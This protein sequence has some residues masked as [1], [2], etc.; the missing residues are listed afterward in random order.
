LD[1]GWIS[2][3][4]PV[5][6]LFLV[7]V[8]KEVIFSL[9]MGT[10]VGALVFSRGD[11]FLGLKTIL[12]AIGAGMADVENVNILIFLGLLGGLV[13]V[14]TAAGG[15]KAYGDWAGRHIKTK[16]QAQLM[17]CLCGLLFCVDDFFHFLASGVIMKPVTERHKLSPQKF[18]YLLDSTGAPSSVICPISGWAA[19]IVALLAQSGVQAPMS[20]FLK[21]I[22]FNLYAVL[23]IVMVFFFSA[24]RFELGRMAA[25]EAEAEANGGYT[26]KATTDSIEGIKISQH[27]KI[28]Y[29]ILPIVVLL[30]SSA[31]YVLKTGSYFD[32]EVSIL[33]ALEQANMGQ[34]L[35]L[36]GFLSIFSAFFLVVP[37]KSLSLKT[38][39]EAV[40]GGIRTMLPAILILILAWSIGNICGEEYLNMG[41]FVK[42]MLKAAIPFQIF[43]FVVFVVACLLSFATGTSWGTFGIFIPVVVN[44]C[45]NM[46]EGILVVAIAATLAGSV[47]GDHVSPISSTTVLA[48][49]SAGCDHLDHVRTQM[50]YALIVAAGSA[51]GYLV[52]GFLQ[53]V[54]VVLLVAGVI[55]MIGVFLVKKIQKTR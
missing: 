3:A 55:M 39:V 21:G 22:P 10:F 7:L 47:F 37:S 45:A 35:V 36:G 49:T 18:A 2:I 14:L 15:A 24:S 16:R 38:F 40:I 9:F 1:Y 52:A 30:V 34:A 12:A 42:N 25:C 23:T 54:F 50:P 20:V 11:L 5:V 28:I 17:V 48:S 8:T 6:A 32:G 27:G 33:K 46:P 51:V 41:L 31:L 53:N 44:L 13:V 43:P 26:E 4:P 19:V 29:M